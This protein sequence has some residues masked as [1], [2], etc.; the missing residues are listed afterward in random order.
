[1]VAVSFLKSKYER[2]K[3]IKLI[4]ESKADLI[5]V[6]LMDGLYVP[7]NNLDKPLYYNYSSRCY[8]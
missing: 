8:S 7:N 2:E 6:D 3:T 1:M 4:D 5:H